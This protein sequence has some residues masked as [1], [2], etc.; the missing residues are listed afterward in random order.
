MA[1]MS[2]LYLIKIGEIA[3]KKGNKALFER[4]LKNNIKK[5]LRPHPS[6]VTIRSGRFYLETEG[7]SDEYVTSC[8][9]KVFGIT[10][11]TRSY[12]CAKDLDQLG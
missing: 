9:S 11:F 5:I 1:A 3:L 7:L 10:G 6:R 12:S 4:Q 2:E 8:L